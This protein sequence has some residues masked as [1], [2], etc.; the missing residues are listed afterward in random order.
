MIPVAKPSSSREASNGTGATVRTGRAPVMAK[1]ANAA[2]IVRRGPKRSM[3]MPAAKPDNIRPSDASA[4]VNWAMEGPPGPN[5]AA[6]GGRAGTSTEK[7][8]EW[9]TGAGR[10]GEEGGKKGKI[11]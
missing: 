3:M 5:S 4:K 11:E 2:T 7:R 6:S 10:E 9:K 8:R 1:H